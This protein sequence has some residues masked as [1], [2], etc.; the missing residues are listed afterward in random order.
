MCKSAMYSFNYVL[1]LLSYFEVTGYNY[2]NKQTHLYKYHIYVF[3]V[4]L[5]VVFFGKM[6][7]CSYK[8]D[9]IWQS[10]WCHTLPVITYYIII[11]LVI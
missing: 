7:Q 3:F 5:F 11:H 10:N 6:D 4:G 2:F 9:I 1:S 8:S